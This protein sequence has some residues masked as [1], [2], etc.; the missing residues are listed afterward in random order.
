[1]SFD[2]QKALQEEDAYLDQSA[3]SDPDE[4]INQLMIENI[5][6]KKS[7]QELEKLQQVKDN[8]IFELEQCLK[9]A[10]EKNIALEEEVESIKGSKKVIE[11]FLSLDTAQTALNIKNEIKDEAAKEFLEAYKRDLLPVIVKDYRDYIDKEI[12]KLGQQMANR[13]LS[14]NDSDR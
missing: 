2:N 11:T 7:L 12:K 1:M 14:G 6:L 10:D 4:K 9:S 8:R 3:G 13:K 5:G